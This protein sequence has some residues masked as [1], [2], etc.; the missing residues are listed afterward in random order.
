MRENIGVITYFSLAAGF[1]TGK[2]RHEADFG[3]S[4]RGAGMQKFLNPRGHAILAAL[5]AVG[6]RS[7]RRWRR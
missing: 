6:Q 5:D 3:K 4:A 2:Y 1:L 7:A